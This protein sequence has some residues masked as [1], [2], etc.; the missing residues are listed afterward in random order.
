MTASSSWAGMSTANRVAEPGTRFG[1]RAVATHAD[2]VSTV[3]Y[4][5]GT[6]NAARD[7]PSDTATTESGPERR[8]RRRPGTGTSLDRCGR[9]SA[10]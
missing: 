5:S 10:Q 3:R 1:R 6:A 4:P 2:A 8:A 9:K 7:T